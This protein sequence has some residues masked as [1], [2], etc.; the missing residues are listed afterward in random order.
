MTILNERFKLE[1]KSENKISEIIY[2]ID[3]IKYFQQE[4]KEHKNVLNYL[5]ALRSQEDKVVSSLTF[6]NS[7]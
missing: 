1:M 4:N 3:T 7:I 6:L 2:N 5:L